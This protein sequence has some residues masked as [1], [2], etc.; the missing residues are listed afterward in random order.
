MRRPQPPGWIAILPILWALLG[1][2]ALLA[3]GAMFAP[4]RAQGSRQ[5]IPILCTDTKQ[6]EAALGNVGERIM[7]N[8]VTA[9]NSVMQLWVNPRTHSFTILVRMPHGTSCL[10]ISGDGLEVGEPS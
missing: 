2:I 6:A 8:G 1:V 5:T 10:V 4:V 9:N 3:I 7:A